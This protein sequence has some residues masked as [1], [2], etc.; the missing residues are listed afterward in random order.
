MNILHGPENRLR[1]STPYRDAI[2]GIVISGLGVVARA[3]D[4]F[5]PYALEEVNGPIQN[6]DIERFENGGQIPGTYHVGVFLNGRQLESLDLNF[7]VA[8]KGDLQA[9]ITPQQLRAWGVNVEAFPALAQLDAA[10]PVTNLGQLIPQASVTHNFNQ[11]R[12]DLSIPQ[13]ALR[14]IARGTVSEDRWDQG[15]NALWVNYDVSGSNSWSN[16]IADTSNDYYTGLRSGLNLGS[17]RLRNFSTYAKGNR[18]YRWESIDTYLY[19]DVQSLKGQLILGDTATPS[20][21]FDSVRFRGVQLASDTNMLPDS[22]KGYAPTISGVAR[23]NAHVTVRQSGYIIYQTYVAP[24]PF[25]ISD[26]YPTASSGDIDVTVEEEDGTQHS[27][28]QPFASVAIMQREGGMKYSLTAGTFRQAEYDGAPAFTQGTMAYGLPGNLTLYGGVIG[29]QR[30]QSF[31]AG[32]GYSLGDLG[33]LSV[34]V[35]QADTDIDDQ[36]RVG[37]SYRFRYS[38]AF[39]E[40]DT[41]LTLASMR[42]STKGFFSFEESVQFNDDTPSPYLAKGN[43]KSRVQ[44]NLNQSL[45]SYGALYLSGYQ[46]DYWAASGYDRNLS[47]G[48]SI[49]RK[50]ISYS[51]SLNRSDNPGNDYQDRQLTFSVSFP[52]DFLTPRSWASYSISQSDHSG[53]QQQLALNGMALEDDSLSYGVQ[54]GYGNQG[55]G[56]N[57][58]SY[59]SYLGGRGEVNAGYSYSDYSQRVTYGVRGAALLHSEGLTLSQPIGDTIALVKAPGAKGARIESYRGLSTDDDGFAVIPYL[60]SYRETRLALDPETL[61]DDVDADLTVSAVVPTNGAVVRADY[62]THVGRRALLQLMIGGKPVPFGAKV[63]DRQGGGE[64][65]VGSRGET[66]LAGLPDNGVLAVHWGH[67]D[68]KGCSAN[69]DFTRSKQAASGILTATL[70]CRIT[71]Q[72]VS[73]N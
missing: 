31:S 15:I 34:D 56:A 71:E 64:A 36:P 14:S 46:Q 51:A 62:A 25:V 28:T 40:T 43:K 54:Q 20:D 12:L 1:K 38:K 42:Y 3:A 35:T 72:L 10:K 66:Y 37:Q 18:D 4:H 17:W 44:L 68:E 49:S 53:T 57:G 6:V 11:Q 60:N 73:R 67:N 41:N 58:N 33:A 2:L 5:N 52:L 63:V 13:A 21:I 45:G 70:E 50:G 29:A 39:N 24:G 69:F 26:L 8:D 47:V 16:S 32:V 19:R 30:Y 9:E 27:F 22:L 23:S 48:Y 55:R 7:V 65:I 61:G 59:V